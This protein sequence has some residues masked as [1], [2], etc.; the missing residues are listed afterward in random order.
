MVVGTP[1]ED[2]L[3]SVSCT[4]ELD[5]HPVELSAPAVRRE[6]FVGGF[7]EL[8][9]AVVPPVALDPRKRREIIPVPGRVE[10]LQLQVTVWSVGEGGGSGTLSLEGPEGWDVSPAGVDV[11][12]AGAGESKTFGFDVFVPE[13]CDPGPYE[14][15]YRVDSRAG[16]HREV[17][18]PVRALAP[19]LPGPVDQA[20]CVAEAFLVGPAR[21]N[22]GT[23]NLF[24]AL[25]TSMATTG[26]GTI[27]EFQKAEVVVAPAIKTEGKRDQQAQRVGAQ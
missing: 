8:P 16:V 10:Q 25:R 4:V 20:N 24:G 23:L 11:D 19:G 18:W 17:L 3:V 5:G 12:F 27:K 14:I 15:R 9:L 7:R 2:S 13:A 22:D 1:F 26:Y 21:E 6:T